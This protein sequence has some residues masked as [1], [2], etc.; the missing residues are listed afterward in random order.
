MDWRMGDYPHLLAPLDLGFTKLRNR[1]LMG[2]M[3]TGLEDVEG[4][5]ARMAAFYAERARGECGLIVTGGIAPNEAGKVSREGSILTTATEA[6]RHIEVTNAVHQE[7]GTICMQILHTGRYGYHKGAVGPSD[8]R[9]PINVIRPHR[10]THAEI[11]ETISDFARCAALAREGG[12]DGVE[13]MG[14][15]GYLLN[16]FIARRTN[17]R[18]DE[19]GGSRENRTRLALE[20]IRAVRR[21]A[22]TDFIII[23]RLS[24]LDLVDEGG[25]FEE[26]IWLAGEVEKAGATIINTGIGWHEARIPTI[27]M[28][29]PRGAFSWVT[30][31]LKGNV[32]IPLVTSNRINT[33]EVAE[34]IL[35]RGDAD[36]VSM[37]RPFLADAGFVS[38]ARSGRAREINTCIACNQACLDHIFVGKVC[39]CLV[40]P[41]ACH[42][43]ELNYTPTDSV[44]RFAVV[45]AGPGGLST[46][47]V[48]AERGHS[49]VLFEGMPEIGG[50]LNIARRIPGKQEFNETIRYFR[51][52]IRAT[53]VEL[54]L[55]TRADAET[56][57]G[58][59]FDAVILATGVTPRV[60]NI[61]GVDGANV[62][63][64]V[65]VVLH[66]KPVGKRAA[67][68]GAGGIGYDVSIFL[69]APETDTS[70]NRKAFL[71]EWGIEESIE[72]PG[73]LQAQEHTPAAR[74]VTLLKRSGNKFGSTLGKTT[75]WI[76]K[77]T[78]DERGVEKIGGVEYTSIDAQ[79]LRIKVGQKERLI[80][81]DTVVLCAGQEPLRELQAPLEAA[82]V[83]VHLVGGADVA[84]ELDAKRAIDQGARLA[85]R[86]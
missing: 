54:R 42:E 6:A 84:S 37:A 8:I 17:D 10:L 75:G 1:A 65:D 48:L 30:A 21:A 80:D 5:Y 15:E 76:H 56:L 45:G 46:A 16:Q 47:T 85:A 27:A 19:W 73:G 12:Y 51:E 58:G 14:S 13:I 3:H 60:P 44:K 25:N 33:P 7:G 70:Q 28:M 61:P 49:V 67:V 50:Q 82:G 23:Y 74:D 53:G 83:A 40:N 59:K 78:I 29:V 35:A 41:R 43:T 55:N 34:E 11:L 71:L 18:D 63:T 57:I 81:A 69:T 79:G 66:G 20:V 68:I 72:S 36:M 2:S 77:L 24:M 38:K 52:R 31:K 4:G 86:L 64:Y 32:G 9:A 22:G 39:S 62:L 26:V